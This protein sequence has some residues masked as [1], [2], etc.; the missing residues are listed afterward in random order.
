MKNDE[1]ASVT[2]SPRDEFERLL[3]PQVDALYRT[4]LRMTGQD[5][6][7]QDLVQEASLHAWRGFGSF[8]P[9]SNFRAWI[10]RILTNAFINRWRREGRAPASTDF[11]EAEPAAPEGSAPLTAEEVERLADAL[12]DEAARAIGRVPPEFRI[13]FLLSTFED[14]T[15]KEIAAVLEIPVGTV[16]SRLFR[17]RALLREELAAYARSLTR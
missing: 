13:V 16:M 10:F 17:A 7:A 14:L 1:G 2:A 11:A 12:G 4:A 8:E 9:G 3:R 5:A 6:T 15:Y